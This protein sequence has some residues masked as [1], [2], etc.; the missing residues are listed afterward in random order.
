MNKITQTNDGAFVIF[1]I[2]PGGIRLKG[3]VERVYS[4][5]ERLDAPLA[6]LTIINLGVQLLENK[7]GHILQITG[8]PEDLAMALRDWASRN[9]QRLLPWSAAQTLMFDD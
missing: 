7:Q 8:A 1:H 6:R 9:V 3:N 4:V 2:A 5:L